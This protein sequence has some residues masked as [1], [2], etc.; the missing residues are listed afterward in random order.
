MEE[1][2]VGEPQP[3]TVVSGLVKYIPLE[4]MQ[5]F[6]FTFA[7]SLC[8]IDKHITSQSL[9]SAGLTLC[10]TI[11]SVSESEGMCSL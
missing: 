11:L 2:D 5:V 10:Q 8:Y 7:D 3:R 6:P 9:P 1:I 4:E